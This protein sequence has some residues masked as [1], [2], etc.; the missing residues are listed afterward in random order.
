[1]MKKNLF[2][3]VLLL[4]LMSCSGKRQ[5]EKAIT[6]GDYDRA[7]FKALKKLSTN[8]DSKRKQ[9]L[10]LMLKDAYSKV[11]AQDQSQI[12]RLEKGKNPESYR[13]IFELYNDLDKRQKSI[14]AVTPLIVD[15]KEVKFTFVDYSNEL[16]EYKNKVSNYYHQQSK[17]LLSSNSK[18][19]ARTAYK[20]LKYIENINPNYRDV[21]GLMNQAHDK[22]TNYVLVSV[23]NQTQQIIPQA[24]ENELLNFESYGLNDFWT[25]YHGERQ[26]A[27]NYDFNLELRLKQI[28]ISPEQVS[29]RE[30]IRER[31]VVDGWEYVLDQNGNVTK[32]SLGNDIKVDKIVNTRARF[33]E[34]RQF[35]TSQ[36]LGKVV[37]SEAF[38]N[39]TLDAF[40]IESG[41]VFENFYGYYNGDERALLEEDLQ[42][43]QGG[44]IPFPNNEQMV[45][46]TG[47]DL[48][49][50]LK[51]I[52]SRYKLSY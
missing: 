9:T 34:V 35:K 8:K 2:Y 37:F 36:I 17:N 50:Q 27:K 42:L 23:K 48:K 38:N 25:I 39:Q 20:K 22:G 43:L 41:F 16:I 6:S 7:I 18:A 52:I 29:E 51:S 30:F 15:G 21:I 40:P 12:N 46:D 44:A 45:L 3:L 31:D 26:M 47:Q 28:N 32:D 19:N 13:T 24:L 14:F 10:V 4:V 49:Q 33:Y 11:V 1:M 5:I